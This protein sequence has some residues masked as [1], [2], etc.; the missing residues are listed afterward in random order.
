VNGSLKQNFISQALKD[1][2]GLEGWLWKVSFQFRKMDVVGTSL[3]VWGRVSE[4]RA[5]NDQ[6]GI[7]GLEIGIRNEEGRESTPGSATV[8]LPLKG[9]KVPYPFEMTNEARLP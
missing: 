9:G 2:A 4:K 6:F 3:A 8:V 7:V 1:W 5:V